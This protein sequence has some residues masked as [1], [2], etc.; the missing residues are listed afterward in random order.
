[1]QGNNLV[2]PYHSWEFDADGTNKCIPYCAKDMAGSKRVNA[3]KYEV[4]ERLDIVFVWYHAGDKPPAYEM[5]ILDEVENGEFRHI[6]T[7]PFGEWAMH[8]MEPSHNTAGRQVERATR[9]SE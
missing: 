7:L 5:D 2:C 1:V 8:I 4:R 9:V 3:K 6:H